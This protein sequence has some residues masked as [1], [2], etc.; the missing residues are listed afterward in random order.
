MREKAGKLDAGAVLAHIEPAVFAKTAATA[1]GALGL[2]THAAR[3]APKL[4]SEI[5][6]VA[7][8]GL[9]G[10]EGRSLKFVRISGKWELRGE[11][12]WIG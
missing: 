4:H 5:A 10:G 11:G 9:A 2:L 8:I 6:C 7:A 3:S 12:R 1:K